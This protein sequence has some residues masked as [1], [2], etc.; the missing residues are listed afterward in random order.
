MR[1]GGRYGTLAPA[2]STTR[3]HCPFTY[4]QDIGE[5]HGDHYNAGATRGDRPA[6]RESRRS[7]LHSC[8]ASEHAPLTDP[9]S[10]E[11]LSVEPSVWTASER[12]LSPEM[13]MEIVTTSGVSYHERPSS[14][15]PGTLACCICLPSSALMLRFWYELLHAQEARRG[16]AR[17]PAGSRIDHQ[18]VAESVEGGAHA[19]TQV[20]N[21]R[22][23][24]ECS[25]HRCR[26]KQAARL[27][28]GDSYLTAADWGGG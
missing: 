24:E 3:R 20:P 1:S 16:R 26:T 22:L 13:G 7:V 28:R 8:E 10:H 18:R 6:T 21:H 17:E 11:R 23:R 27:P 4:A 9:R 12:R 5:C 14:S 19:R 2:E 25:F 15:K